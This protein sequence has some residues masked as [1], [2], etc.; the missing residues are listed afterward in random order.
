MNYR[1]FPLALATAFF[2][3]CPTAA[4]WYSAGVPSDNSAVFLVDKS[5][6]NGPITGRNFW[7]MRILRDKSDHTKSLFQVNCSTKEIIE[8]EY[9]SYKGDAVDFSFKPNEKSILIPD[10]VLADAAQT[11]CTGKYKGG[12][13]KKI[14]PDNIREQLKKAN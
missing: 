7:V 14:D 11:V 1:L 6:I 13:S 2:S 4:E 12:T 5:S 8:L 10:S 3:T 9:V